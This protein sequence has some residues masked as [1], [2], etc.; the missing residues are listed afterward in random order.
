MDEDIQV[1]RQTTDYLSLVPSLLSLSSSALAASAIM[2]LVSCKTVSVCET[3]CSSRSQLLSPDLTVD[4]AIVLTIRADSIIPVIPLTSD[5][6]T[7]KT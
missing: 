6:C 7:G 4:A 2:G 1:P 3:P 5:N